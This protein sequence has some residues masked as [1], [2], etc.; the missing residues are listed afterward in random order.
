MTEKTTTPVETKKTRGY[1]KTYN[2]CKRVGRH[3]GES[4]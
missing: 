1:R 4:N 3:V 2:N